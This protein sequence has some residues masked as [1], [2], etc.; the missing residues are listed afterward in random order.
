[1]FALARKDSPIVLIYFA[2]SICILLIVVVAQY[3]TKT[4]SISMHK[5]LNS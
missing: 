3:I 4:L 5:N 2:Y 1:M